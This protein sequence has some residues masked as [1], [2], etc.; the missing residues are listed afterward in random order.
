MVKA[1]YRIDWT[2]CERGWGQKHYRHT[3]YDSLAEAKAAI[4]K[5]WAGYPDG[6]VPD[7]YIRPSEP[8]LV[9]VEEEKENKDA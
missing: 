7:Y 9:E 1:V 5:H 6:H 2:E 8:Y 3:D 4:V